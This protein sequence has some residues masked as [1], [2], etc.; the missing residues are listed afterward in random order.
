[1]ERKVTT[2]VV[3]N[4]LAPQLVEKQVLSDG[5]ITAKLCL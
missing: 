4:R 1:M 2:V 5:Y 3:D